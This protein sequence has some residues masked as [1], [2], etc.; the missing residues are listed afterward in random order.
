METT[1]EG[2]SGTRSGRGSGR[3]TTRRGGGEADREQDF[4]L[5]TAA[6]LGAALGAGVALLVGGVA[7]REPRRSG[8]EQVIRG[9]KQSGRELGKGARRSSR[10]A[11]AASSGAA[12]TLREYVEGARSA[13]DDAVSH[14]LRDLRR[15]A[16]R[17]RKQLGL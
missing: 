9:V 8:V 17:K 12:E 11:V 4:D 15:L 7:W 14:E 1:S 6:L 10:R 3:G 2:G 5:L 16:R 13:I